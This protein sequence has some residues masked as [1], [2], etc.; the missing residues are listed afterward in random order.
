MTQVL[1]DVESLQRWATAIDS[2][3]SFVAYSGNA[4]QEQRQKMSSLGFAIA[5]IVRRKANVTDDFGFG[6]VDDGLPVDAA[7]CS[8]AVR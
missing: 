6:V 5:G 8:G 2:L 1:V 7:G 4:T 3:S